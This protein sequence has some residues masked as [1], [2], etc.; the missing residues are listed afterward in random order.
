MKAVLCNSY[1]T[2]EVLKILV[3]DKQAPQ[4]HE[5]LIRIHVTT[6]TMPIFCNLQY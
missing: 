4:A 5:V 1:G 6:V 3:I 2:P